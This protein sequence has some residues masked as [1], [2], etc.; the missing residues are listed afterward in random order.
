MLIRRSLSQTSSFRSLFQSNTMNTR[1]RHV[2]TEDQIKGMMGGI[3]FTDVA[4]DG[5]GYRFA[6]LL[7]ISGQPSSTPAQP[8][9]AEQCEP[10]H[11]PVKHLGSSLRITRFP[12]SSFEQTTSLIGPWLRGRTGPSAMHR[13]TGTGGSNLAPLGWEHIGRR[14]RL[15]GDRPSSPFRPYAKFARIP[16]LAA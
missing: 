7:C 13:G 4:I 12:A 11:K 5:Q 10:A 2:E 9:S 14:L 15:G 3:T 16:A 8:D 6:N 1:P